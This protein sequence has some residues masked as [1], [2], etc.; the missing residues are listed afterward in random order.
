MSDS[1]FLDWLAD[2]L[3]NVYGESENVDFVRRLRGLARS[4]RLAY[5]VGSVEDMMKEGVPHE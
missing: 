3:V 5:K 2:R 1:E 4:T